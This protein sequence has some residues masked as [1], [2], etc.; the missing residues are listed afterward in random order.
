VLQSVGAQMVKG[1]PLSTDARESRIEPSPLR[2]QHFGKHRVV[3]EA[4]SYLVER[5]VDA[6]QHR[7][8][9]RRPDL[10]GGVP[11][12]A[13]VVDDGRAQQS[14]AVVVPHGLRGQPG[15]A[16]E[17]ADAEQIVRSSGHNSEATRLP[18]GNRK[19]NRET[20]GRPCW[21]RAVP[22]Y[23]LV[24]GDRPEV[25][26]P[27][28]DAAQRQVV[29]HRGGPLLVLAGPGTGKTTTLVETAV[30]R[31]E[32]G[33]P[34][35]QIL[36]LTFSR[37]AAG[38]LRDR[39]TARLGRTVREPVARTLHSY[40]FGVLRMANVGQ[41]LPA[42]RLLSGPE[43][44]VTVRELLEEA[45]ARWPA[46]LRPALRTR[47]FAG[48]LRDLMMRAV[49]RGMDG[50]ALVRL[51]RTRKRADWV[52]AGEFLT[53]YQGV[54]S[55]GRPGA[56]DPAELIRSALNA[57]DVDPDLL[58]AERARRRHIFVDE[59]QDTDP[60]QASLLALLADGADELILV[61]DPDQSIYAFRGADESAIRDVDARFGTEVPVLALQVSRRAGDA[62]LDASRRVALRLP[63]RAEH[64]RL[65]SAAS[66]AGHLDVGLFRSDS[67]ES[68]YIAGVLRAAHLDGMSWARMAV[69]VRSTAAVLGTLRR[70]LITAG[71]PVAVRGED[72]PLAEQ[73]AVTVLLEVLSC[74]QSDAAVTEDVAERLLLGPIGRG[75]IVYL[76]RLRRELKG[77]VEPDQP[78]LLAPVLLDILGAQLL[79]EPVR[80][81]VLR[82]ARVLAAGRSAAS[83]TDATP[84]DVLWAVW[85]TTG[86]SRR[87]LQASLAG[88]AAGAAADRDLDA[89]VQLF[90]A[91]ARYTD[92]LPGETLRG[93][94][95][96][97][98]AQQIPGDSL[99]TGGDAPEA[100]TILTAHASKGLE[101]DLVCV[102]HVQEGS[103]PDLRRR[104]SL[105]GSEQLVD[106]VAGRDTSYAVSGPQL[107]EERR[108]FYVAATRAR[109]RLVV[110]AVI[111]DEEQPSRFLDELDPIE[112]E[113]P[114]TPAKRGTH[115]TG[116]VA[117][118]RAVVCD[119]G[120]ND[121]D[122][123]AAAGELSRLAEAGVR[124]AHPDQWW[125]L[126]PISDDGPPVDPARPVPVSP[127]RIDSFL[128][129]E[130]R[131]L[132][133][134][135]GARDG[136]SI[137]ASL[138][139]LVHE[140]AATAPPDATQAD[141]EALLNE[142][143]AGLEFG[144]RWHARNERERA[145]RI[146][147]VLLTWVRSSRAAGLD[148]VAIEEKF[149]AEIGD[150]VLT[151]RVDRL[152]RDDEGRLVVID[153]KTGKSRV[154]ADDMPVHPQLAAYQLAI[155]SGAFGAGEH[156]GGARLV[157]LAAPAKDP[158]QRQGPL[159]DAEDPDW[160]KNEVAQ[161]AAKLRGTEFTAKI[162]TMCG[163]CDLQTCCPLYPSGRPVTA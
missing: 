57:F 120:A 71:V 6:A 108:L 109:Q 25:A 128:R 100:V 151:G 114:L 158:E 82:V 138:G 113:R 156:A 18:R 123:E 66:D 124:G 10:I 130:L 9:A 19:P 148:L 119:T 28:L 61:G 110:T 15:S 132:L 60:A 83:A 37:R 20:V 62:L 154:K 94:T 64:R 55:L 87:W 63:G 86:L 70:A 107:A 73:P 155:E 129:C 136:D 17:R 49:E 74:V 33:V 21:D 143:W 133:Q 93:F 54:T 152:E 91:A 163:N 42:P 44:D 47:A 51:G 41:G 13:G 38:E 111:G 34:V 12:V 98:A 112:G 99:S 24:R 22:D 126:A 46:E 76:R 72:L 31:V 58:L 79:P 137:S 149:N 122:R 139:N 2:G 144:A 162:N 69:L 27:V 43:Q 145:S 65:T 77:F 30:A 89:V 52:A 90:D 150:A 5:D 39:V 26:V 115:L 142:Q 78:V 7:H 105:L 4:P 84:E 102:A 147:A 103:W 101:W 117:E 68:A 32:A 135:L 75:D 48:E 140:V 80:N 36:M 134:D 106:V 14:D 40:A 53:E 131:S 8:A 67:E 85:D 104:G 56:Y 11:P 50:P 23:Q 159:S 121:V 125:G 29:E 81:P 45:A 16:R 3:V 161:V 160:I 146:L 141:L 1:V 59:Y 92:R 118:L 95:E 127:S 157:Q 116:L 153:L 97:V 96:H 35:E 88:G